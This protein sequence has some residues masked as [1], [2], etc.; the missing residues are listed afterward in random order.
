M[1]R[2]SFLG[3]LGLAPVAATVTFAEPKSDAIDSRTRRAAGEPILRKTRYTKGMERIRIDGVD[4]TD[5]TTSCQISEDLSYG[6]L[7][8]KTLCI[9]LCIGKDH[10]LPSS[11]PG[12]D[13]DGRDYDRDHVIELISDSGVIVTQT[14]RL[15]QTS[16]RFHNSPNALG[17]MTIALGFSAIGGADYF[18]GLKISVDGKRKFW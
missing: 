18:Y 7:R 6:R 12:I 1:N 2:R 11:F 13:M 15:L 14:Y 9:E 16:L 4:V 10:S 8:D 5:I 3:W 17:C